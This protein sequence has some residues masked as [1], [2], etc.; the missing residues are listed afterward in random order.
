MVEPASMQTEG[1]IWSPRW[2]NPCHP[3]LVWH[4]AS[5]PPSLPLLASK[6]WVMFFFTAVSYEKCPSIGRLASLTHVLTASPLKFSLFSHSLFLLC[7]NICRVLLSSFTCPQGF[8]L[9]YSLATDILFSFSLSTFLEDTMSIP[10]I[11]I[12][13]LVMPP[14]CNL[15]STP[16]EVWCSPGLSTGKFP[17]LAH[18]LPLGPLHRIWDT[19][20]LGSQCLLTS[21]FLPDL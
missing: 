17:D 13:I 14:V 18:D 20:L 5:F 10:Q 15:I 4:L 12:H 8:R 21:T 6:L 2:S 11:L 1:W 16:T 19:R 7:L 9:Q 3:P